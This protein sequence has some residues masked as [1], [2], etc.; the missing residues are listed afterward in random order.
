MPNRVYLDTNI[1]LDLFDVLRPAHKKSSRLIQTYLEDKLCKVFINTDTVTT[2]FYVVRNRVKFDLETSVAKTTLVNQM[3]SIVSYTDED[4][5]NAL[6][7]CR[8]KGF[9]D[10]EDAIQYVCAKKVD[11]EVIVTNDK[12]FVSL[13]VELCATL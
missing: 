6:L 4:I 12:K 13:D 3:F 2:F 9:T 7:L 5:E 8:E 1:V 11:A 10:Y